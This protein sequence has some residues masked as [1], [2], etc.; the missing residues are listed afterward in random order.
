MIM[1]H[2]SSMYWLRRILRLQVVDT[3]AFAKRNPAVDFDVNNLK[4]TQSGVVQL[5][6]RQ[7]QRNEA[8][9]LDQILANVR[10]KQLYVLRPIGQVNSRIEKMKTRGWKIMFPV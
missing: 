4:I 8:L 7:G 1:G 9:N 3:V 2:R 6:S 10:A 5:R